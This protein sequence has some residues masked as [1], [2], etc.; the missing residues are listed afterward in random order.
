MSHFIA[1]I[2]TAFATL[3]VAEIFSNTLA[4]IYTWHFLAGVLTVCISDMFRDDP[5]YPEI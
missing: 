5:R 1:F 3:M 2:I 4:D